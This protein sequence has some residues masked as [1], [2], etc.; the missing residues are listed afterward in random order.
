MKIPVMIQ[1]QNSENGATALCMMLGYY[2]RFVPI[3]EMREVCISSRNGSSPEQIAQAAEKYGLTATVEN[4]VPVERLKEMEFP[5]MIRW[6]KRY[7]TLI[8]S[9]KG[10][11]ATVV[12]PASGIY[13]IKMSKLSVLFTGTVITFRKNE[14]FRKEGKQESL[15]SLIRSRLKPLTRPML[16]VIIFTILCIAINLTITQLNKSILDNYMGKKELSASTTGV[17]IIILY[18]VLMVLYIL[19]SILKTRTVNKTSQKISAESGI[20]LFKKMIRQPMR[21]FEQ[22]SAADMISRL[23]TN[24][25]IDHSIL[26]SFVPSL[27][28]AVMS[29]FYIVV[30]FMSNY[31]IAG[32]CLV[33]VLSSILISSKIQ[34]KTATAS[35]SMMTKGN[36][37]N[38][39]LLNGMNMIDTIIS[40]G[41]ERSFYNMWRSS[42]VQFNESRMSLIRFSALS[43]TVSSLSGNI[44]QWFQLFAGAYFVVQGSFTLGSMALFQGIL[45]SMVNAM[46]NCISTSNQLQSM[47][48]GIE[49]INDINTRKAQDV[50]PLSEEEAETV[51]KLK[52]RIKATNICFRYNSG[53]RLALENVSLEVEPGQMVAIVGS[54]GCGKSTLLK[55]LADL[56]SAESGE[57]LYDGKKRCE[58]PDVVFHSSIST[59]DQEAVMFA[60]SIYNNITMW[61]SEIEH[62]EVTLAA[63]DAQ[64]HNRIVREKKDYGA[65]IKENGRNFS[66]GELQRFEL[67]RALAHEPTLLLLDEFT[68]ALDAITEENAMRAIREKGTTCVIVA[69]RLSTIKDCDRIYVMDRGK[70][71]QE[72]THEELYAQEGL[73]RVLVG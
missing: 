19:F 58:I 53:D 72:G 30:L 55:V 25:T 65:I 15:F 9:I 49:R 41:T 63:R 62:F 40:S 70:I 18:I 50:I 52:G 43:T 69:H 48:T 28:D 13:N 35:K 2:K 27:I 57:I 11:I 20:G 12:D 59:V 56:Y 1:L 31:I 23:D 44:L 64:I 47:R 39:S 46:T 8:K 33:L 66:G 61:D 21:F 14:T 32:I 26:Q 6:K 29:V 10:D 68:S 17:I 37:V 5:L 7:Y 22:Y 73:Y 60:D 45:G 67:A 38:A 4:N 16:G 71:I 24:V 3:E 36:I 42:Q 51:D 54:T 34:E